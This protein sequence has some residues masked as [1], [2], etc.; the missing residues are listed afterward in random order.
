MR[1]VRRDRLQGHR[2][3]ADF[4]A[5]TVV[6]RRVHGD[7]LGHDAELM[8]NSCDGFVGSS[9]IAVFALECET[10]AALG[11]GAHR[12]TLGATFKNQW[13]GRCFGQEVVGAI[14]S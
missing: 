6:Y 2:D 5:G 7:S 8:K 12:D 4:S 3:S 1:S 11:Q 13:F 10:N 9:T 14:G